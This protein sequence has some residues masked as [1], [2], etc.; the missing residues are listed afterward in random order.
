MGNESQSLVT[1]SPTNKFQT[2]HV[3]GSMPTARRERELR[4]F[5]AAARAIVSNARCL[6]EGVD[7]PA[8]DMVAFLSPRRSRVDIVQAIGRAM[9][10]PKDS[11]KTTGYVLVPLYLNQTVGENIEQTVS[12]GAFDE[13]WDVLQSLQEQDDVLAEIIREMGERKGR[14]KGYDDSRFAERIEFTGPCLS[15]ES[16]RESVTTRCLENLCSEWDSWFGKLKV[17]RDRF[18]NSNVRVDWEEDSALASWVFRQRD[19]RKKG[20]LSDEKVR[21]LEEIGFVWDRQS[22]RREETWMKSYRELE[23]YVRENGNPH[24]PARYQANTKLAGW[25][26]RQRILREKAY[27]LYPPLT[28]EQISHL[29]KLGFNWD[30][31]ADKWAERFEQLKRFKEEHEHCEVGLVEGEDG[32]LSQWVSTQ[33]GRNSSGKL[34][35]EQK[36]KLDSI[37][38]NWTPE[39]KNDL[40]WQEMYEQLKKYHAEN[41]DADV[42]SRW[43]QNPKLA[44]WVAAQRERRKAGMIPNGQ[45]RLLDELGFSWKQ[46]ERGSWEDR[47]AEVAE[48]KEKNGHCEIPL[49]FPENPKLGHFVNAMRTQWKNGRLSADRLAKLEAVGFVWKSA[50]KIEVVEGITVKWMARFN[51]LLQYKKIHG[52][53]DI[54]GEWSENPSLG[55]WVARQ[56]FGKLKGKLKPA[57][58]KILEQNGFNW[59]KFAKHSGI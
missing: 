12:D 19:L 34:Q 18:G 55:R 25:V 32:E 23:N 10:K 50:A 54:P 39:S 2:F 49:N 8:V 5:R 37:G 38:F 29:D 58:E 45:T 1:S 56:R 36:A 3:N 21:R 13:V 24:V 48:F 47:L 4:D 35:A 28:N 14:S 33:R 40:K 46:H 31:R 22:E 27:G 59:V 43:K 44:S 15:L 57:H 20:R 9:R 17:Y 6:T 11:D 16:L 51:E 42:P 41:G 7:V 53:F 30:P 52:N 26:W